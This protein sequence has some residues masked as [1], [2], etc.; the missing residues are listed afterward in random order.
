MQNSN[1][2][3][4]E[5]RRR[6]SL[7]E[8]AVLFL[9][10]GSI[11]FGG[12]AA[13]IA[14][15]QDEVV[16]RRKWMSG[17]HFL[18]LVGVTN[19]IPG[20]NA[21][22]MAIHCGYHRAGFWGLLL[23]GFCFIIPAAV[24]SGIFAW[25]YVQYQTMPQF[26]SFVY[27]IKPAVLALIA[28]A[29]YHLGRKSLKNVVLGVLGAGVIAASL[30]GINEIVVIFAGGFVGMFVLRVAKEWRAK[31][32]FFL[33]LLSAGG[34]AAKAGTDSVFSSL[35]LTNLFLVF[36]KTGAVIFGSGYV[37]VAYLDGD[38]VNR[39]GWLT[40]SEL[41]DAIAVGQF[42]PGP[43]FSAATFIG[44]KLLGFSGAALATVGFLLPS[45]ILVLIANPL[46]P[47]LRQSKWAGEFLDAVNVSAIGLIAA[48]AFKLGR[49]ILI[50][51]KTI[52]IACI[53]FAVVFGFRKINSTFI[54]LGGM[55]TG[56]LLKIISN[57]F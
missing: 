13:L 44:Y 20:P 7:S 17:E 21:V 40:K 53:S 18:D 33:P 19:L 32:A 24:I 37:L 51:W 8:V 48:V 34:F 47:K 41:I 36:L 16:N 29:I 22:E 52:V 35:S 14:L 12:P 57:L 9:K 6:C 11:G 50:D 55:V 27:G 4:S 5:N 31:N 38:L 42:T 43:V 30:L 23:A 46:V 10:L 3:D 15:I 49:D 26:E 25:F 45:F 56:Y 28:G 1:A 54:V 2:F 39:L